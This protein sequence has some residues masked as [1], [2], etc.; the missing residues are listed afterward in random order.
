MKQKQK[1]HISNQYLE[2]G[3]RIEMNFANFRLD[4]R[5]KYWFV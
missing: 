2:I 5:L 1:K 3:G 4:F